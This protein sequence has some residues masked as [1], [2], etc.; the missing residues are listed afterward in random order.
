MNGFLKGAI[1][2][3]VI[4]GLSGS[5]AVAQDGCGGA[6]FASLGIQSGRILVLDQVQGRILSCPME[7]VSY[8]PTCLEISH[9]P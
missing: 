7:I 4:A 9:T 8:S 2:A 6:R 5:V 1:L 3:T